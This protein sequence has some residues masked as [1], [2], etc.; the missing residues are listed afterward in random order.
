MPVGRTNGRPI[1]VTGGHRSGSTWVGKMISA[2]PGIAYIHEPFNIGANIT[3]NPSPFD[4]WFQYI[5]PG[6]S[7][8]YEEVLW[9][10]L[11]YDYP[12]WRNAARM[13]NGFD[14]LRLLRDQTASTVNRFAGKRP[15]VKD[16]IA[17]FSAEWLSSTF[18]MDVICMVRHPAAFCSSLK[19]KNWKFDF[20]NFLG[21][22]LLMEKHLEPFRAEIEEYCSFEKN[23][24]EQGALL[25]NCI[26]HTIQTYRQNHPDWLYLRHEDLSADPVNAFR[27]TYEALGLAFTSS[28]RQMIEK[29]SS[30]HNPVEVTGRDKYKRNSLANINSWKKRLTVDEVRLIKQKTEKTARFFYD[31]RDW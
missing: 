22:P 25:W 7:G 16:P 24:V 26:Y 8:E 10:I 1:L 2:A 5:P 27:A 18:D 21:Q 6:T 11:N 14:V 15:L 28:A 29:S 30:S 23:I 31:E 3:P 13:Q 19:I 4:A 17:V 20:R 9:R 12:L